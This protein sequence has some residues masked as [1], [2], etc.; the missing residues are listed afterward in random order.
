MPRSL[1]ILVLAVCVSCTS[2][3]TTTTSTTTTNSTAD[4]EK[5]TDDLLYGTL[6]LSPVNATQTGYHEHNGISLDDT[7][8][9]YS[10]AGIDKARTFYEG[11]QT[12]VNALN[13]ASLDK[14]QQADLEIMKNQL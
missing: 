1:F 6:A 2:K 9:D 4:F 12:R 13:T 5:L 3:T 8:D 10:Q 14:E 7:L 11:I